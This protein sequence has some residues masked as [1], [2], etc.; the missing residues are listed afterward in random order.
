ML[1]K[2]APKIDLQKLLKDKNP[3]LAKL[4]PRFILNYLKRVIHQE[5]INTFLQKHH[6][7]Q[8]AEFCTAVN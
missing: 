7:K 1:P 4:L 3:G 8:G 6:Q 5:D 2:Q